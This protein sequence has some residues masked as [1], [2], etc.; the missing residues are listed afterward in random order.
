MHI[1]RTYTNRNA[2]GNADKIII[3]IREDDGSLHDYKVQA[4]QLDGMTEEEI[5]T[6]LVIWLDYNYPA[7]R[8]TVVD[9]GVHVNRDSSFCIWTGSPPDVWPED[10]PLIE[11]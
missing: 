10:A 1:Y 8:D 4:Q 9:T 7:W 2:S 3:G 11:P 5:N 6:A